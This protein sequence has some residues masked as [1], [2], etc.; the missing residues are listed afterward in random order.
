MGHLGHEA[1]LTVGGVGR[2][3]SDCRARRKVVAAFLSAPTGVPRMLRSA[4]SAFTRVFDAPCLCG[5]VRC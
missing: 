1:G 4:K 2:F 3:L 5:V